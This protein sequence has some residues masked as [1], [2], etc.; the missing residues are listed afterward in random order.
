M[1]C[2]VAVLNKRGIALA[3][4]SAVTLTDG[5]GQR[6]KIYYTAEKLFSLSPK[7]PVAIMT[8]G[9]AE[10]MGVPWETVVKM[11]AQRLDG[12]RFDRLAAYAQDFLGFIEGADWLFPPAAQKQWFQSLIYNVWKR[13][14]RDELDKSMSERTKPTRKERLAALT[15]LIARDHED[16]ERYPQLACAPSGYGE[17]LCATFADTLDEIECD[18]FEG[19]PLPPNMQAALRKTVACVYEK[20]WFHPADQSRI[21]IAGMGEAEPFPVLLEY[22]VGT[23]AGGVL[24]HT[25]TDETRIG[26]DIDGS[27]H[28]FGQ[29]AI[30]NSLVSGIHPR[31]YRQIVETVVRA[32]HEDCEDEDDPEEIRAEEKQLHE[33]LYE[34]VVGPYSKPLLAAVSA[35]PRQDLAKMAE[36]LVSLTA[37]LMRMTADQDDTVAEPVDVALLSKGDGFVWVKH[38]EIQSVTDGRGADR[39]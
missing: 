7:L 15:T 2:E 16:W 26:E 18:L 11:Y 3:A 31:V 22:N 21:V 27:V 37:F 5:D 24:R 33:S 6:R 38:K 28:P 36:A 14:Y 34:E 10:I 1:T 20:E 29:G 4:D 35:L 9:P 17:R 13:L 30:I 25:K 19:L 32:A 23:V 8:Y 39:A 12:R